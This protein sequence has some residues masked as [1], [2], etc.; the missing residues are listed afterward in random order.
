MSDVPPGPGWWKASDGNWYPPQS[1]PGAVTAPPVPPPPMV[2]P[3]KSGNGCLIAVLVAF[4]LLVLI[5]VLSIVAITFL[6]KKASDKLEDVGDA[7]STPSTVDP[8]HVGARS[9]DEVLEIGESVRISGFTATVRSAKFT[10]TVE[11]FPPGSYLVVDVTVENRDDEAQTPFGLPWYLQDPNGAVVPPMS[12]DA[13]VTGQIGAGVE[14]DGRLVFQVA[15][16]S[17]EY[18]LFYRP[19]PIDKTRGIW[20]ISR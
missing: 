14:A 20:P 8:A 10:E 19:D 15:D 3:A 4:G 12:G 18:F 17:G 5:A 2:Q 6:G 16:L 1:A 7:I 9:E 11:D 13:D